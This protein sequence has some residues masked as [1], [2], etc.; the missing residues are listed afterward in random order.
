MPSF[1]NAQAS[2]LSSGFL[3]TTGSSKYEY[4][5]VSLNHT[6]GTLV[7]VAAEFSVNAADN[8]EKADRISSGHL[9]D[10]I[11]PDSIQINGSNLSVDIKVAEYY[12]FVDKGVRGWKGTNGDGTFQFKKPSGHSGGKSSKMVTALKKWLTKEGL[13]QRNNKYKPISKREKRRSKH[14]IDPVTSEAIKVAGIVRRK[15][16]KKTLFWT[17]AVKDLK[18]VI[19]DRFAKGMK[20]DIIE[21][22]KKP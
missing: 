18:K 7:A 14:P 1:N 8:L 3:N 16:L 22:I 12:K 19:G 2:L 4:E 10:S 20:L 5:D 15:G 11:K 21:T 9:Q 13:K 17:N 6:A